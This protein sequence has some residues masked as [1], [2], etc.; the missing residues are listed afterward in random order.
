[1]TGWLNKL[2]RSPIDLKVAGSSPHEGTGF[3]IPPYP[4]HAHV[5]L[6]VS[7]E[8]DI[9]SF[10]IMAMGTCSSS[11]SSLAQTPLTSFDRDFLY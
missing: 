6:R 10:A 2:A 1:M 3:C 7:G 8:A 4:P 5:W 11:C 9:V